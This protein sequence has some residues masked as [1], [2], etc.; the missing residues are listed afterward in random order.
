MYKVKGRSS[1]GKYGWDLLVFIGAWE[2][3]MH[4]S[5]DDVI[6]IL[7]FFKYD[8]LSFQKHGNEEEA[9]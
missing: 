3:D 5:K 7:F 9:T 1:F 4:D 6:I 8:I 2:I